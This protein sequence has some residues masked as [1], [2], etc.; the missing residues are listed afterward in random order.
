MMTPHYY[1]ESLG[2]EYFRVYRYIMGI[3]TSVF[4]GKADECKEYIRKNPLTIQDK[5]DSKLNEIL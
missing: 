3:G 4:I 5:R 1:T 2:H